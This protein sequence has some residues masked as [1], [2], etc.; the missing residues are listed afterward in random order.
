MLL[1]SSN[2]ASRIKSRRMKLTGWVQPVNDLLFADY[3]FA[4]VFSVTKS[5]IPMD[6]V[7]QI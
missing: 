7:N 1:F 2:A 6:R 3:F 4:I 5:L